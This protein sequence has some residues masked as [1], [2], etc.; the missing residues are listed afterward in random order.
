MT[1]SSFS[2]ASSSSASDR[3]Q[4]RLKYVYKATKQHSL[5]LAK[6]V[7]IYK[8]ALLL[9]KTLAG[10]KQRG[11]DTFFA[12]L[13]G[14]WCVFGERNAVN[15]QVSEVIKFK[16]S[17]KVDLNEEPCCTDCSLRRFSSHY[18]LPSS[19]WTSLSTFGTS[20]RPTY[21]SSR[22]IPLTSRIPLP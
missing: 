21:C 12:G 4:Q 11:F 16:A 3:L 10:G 18:F 7:A 22:W 5:N 9:Q 19:S 17:K 8:T 15:E 14:G 20:L 1:C 2:P 6:F 13:I